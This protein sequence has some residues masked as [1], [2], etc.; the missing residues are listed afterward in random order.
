[1][2]VE[3]LSSMAQFNAEKFNPLV[4]SQTPHSKTMLVCFE[5][6]QAIPVHSPGADL[7]LLL[8]EGRAILVDGER[9][10]PEAGPGA[11][12][13]VEAG[14]PRGIKAME[15]TLALVVVAPPPT[16]ADHVEV[17]KHLA[18]GTWR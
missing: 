6:G 2:I 12:L 9:E 18:A 5:A 4:L 3:S 1:M 14:R 15:R 7:T 17:A 10:L 16:K 13:H 11:M 8:L